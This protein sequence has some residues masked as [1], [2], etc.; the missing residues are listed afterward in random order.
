MINLYQI[1]YLWNKSNIQSSFRD[2]SF[3]MFPCFCR[4]DIK[5]VFSSHAS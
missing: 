5:L 4:S 2:I 1:K 3:D